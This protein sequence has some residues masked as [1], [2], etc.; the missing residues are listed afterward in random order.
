[1][2]EMG[3][4]PVT[5]NPVLI[6]LINMTVVF[7]VLW[8]LSLITRFV[9]IIDPTQKKKVAETNAPAAAP[10]PVAVAPVSQQQDDAAI[11]AVIA[12]AVAAYGYS[13]TQIASIRRI[14]GH[15]W[16]Q[17]GRFDAVNARTQMY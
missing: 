14:D 5:T 9:R 13:Q 4:Q 2:N 10:Q 3:G 12:A 8:G 16:T 1:V 11:V 7:A 15:S 6:M 17:A